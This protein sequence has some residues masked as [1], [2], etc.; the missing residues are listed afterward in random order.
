MKAKY[1]FTGIITVMLLCVFN[2][3][4]NAQDL[5]IK[6]RGDSLNCK[7]MQIKR[8]SIFFAIKNN[9]NEMLVR[10]LSMRKIQHYKRD[11]YVPRE[12]QKEKKKTKDYPTMRLGVQGGWGRLTRKQDKNIPVVFKKYAEALGAGLNFGSDF[13]FFASKNVG[14]GARYSVFGA[15]GTSDRFTFINEYGQISSGTLYT[16]VAINYIGPSFSV[17]AISANKKIQFITDISLGYLSYKETSLFSNYFFYYKGGNLGYT[18]KAEL[19]IAIS[20]SLALGLSASCTLGQ[21][22]KVK[23]SD[24]SQHQTVY[25]TKEN[26]YDISRVDISVGLKW[27]K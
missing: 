22:K 12:M 11:F 20:N 10:A 19:D 13:T 5:I 8:D 26:Y 9:N 2:I 24:V 14:F 25:L 6:E 1:T 4:V 27:N 7:I 15:N 21:L 17:R 18:G 3:D 23:M 16:R